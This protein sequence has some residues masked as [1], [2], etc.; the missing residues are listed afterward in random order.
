MSPEHL[1]QSTCDEDPD[2]NYDL[3][4]LKGCGQ[5][6]KWKF[7]ADITR[8]P[9]SNCLRNFENRDALILHY[10]KRHARK[11]ILCYACNAPMSV[12]NDKDFEDHYRRLHPDLE[13][14][15]GFNQKIKQEPLSEQVCVNTS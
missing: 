7:P 8:C 2:E 11:S 3:I 1:N 12:Y 13:M 10:K 6:T 4:L 15:I 9:V 14:P 5:I